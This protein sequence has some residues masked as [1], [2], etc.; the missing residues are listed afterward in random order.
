[1]KFPLNGI[2]TKNLCDHPIYISFIT[3][4]EDVAVGNGRNKEIEKK[5]I[6]YVKIFAHDIKTAKDFIYIVTNFQNYQ[7]RNILNFRLKKYLYFIQKENELGKICS[8]INISKS[9]E[10]I[11]LS[12]E[13]ITLLKHTI[14]E[15]TINK[16]LNMKKGIPNKIGFL[17]KGQPG[18]GKSSLIYAIANE[19]KKHIVSINLQKFNNQTFFTAMSQIENS[20]VVFDDID[21]YEFTHARSKDS[22]KDI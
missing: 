19:I 2:D 10:N 7:D 18:C 1:M 13:N 9:Y 15:W 4:K 12:K 11:F 8:F 14:N 21:A 17:F 22:D 20:V 3:V 16:D 6:R 5:D